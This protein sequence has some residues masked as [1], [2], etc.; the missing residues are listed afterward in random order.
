MPCL[1]SG[2]GSGTA[3]EEL[4]ANEVTIQLDMKLA[5]TDAM[6]SENTGR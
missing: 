2:E 5:S 3:P 1:S 6:L 4:I